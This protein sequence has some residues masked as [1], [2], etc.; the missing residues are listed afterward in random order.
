MWWGGVSPSPFSPCAILWRRV[1][2][3]RQCYDL[4]A[5]VCSGTVTVALAH[6]RDDK[7]PWWTSVGGRK[8]VCTGQVVLMRDCAL[9][10]PSAFAEFNSKYSAS[11][12]HQTA[13]TKKEQDKGRGSLWRPRPTNTAPQSGSGTGLRGSEYTLWGQVGGLLFLKSPLLGCFSGSHLGISAQKGAITQAEDFFDIRTIDGHVNR[14]KTAP[15]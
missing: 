4:C 5:A 9:N 2:P 6:P 10:L 1:I 8:A 11:D 12:H 3:E 15:Q 13:G 7:A 14:S